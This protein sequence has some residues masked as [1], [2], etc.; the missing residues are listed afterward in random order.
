MDNKSEELDILKKKQTKIRKEFKHLN[1]TRNL[2][3][4]IALSQAKEIC[5]YLLRLIIAPF[6]AWESFL[7]S[8][9]RRNKEEFLY[10]FYLIENEYGI[11][12]PDYD[13]I[14]KLK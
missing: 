4:K 10:K 14:N 12:D 7:L 1:T 5:D 11:F 3:P 13:R 9:I 8:S 6:P 2:G